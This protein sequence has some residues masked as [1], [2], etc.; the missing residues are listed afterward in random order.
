M[1]A[2]FTSMPETPAPVLLCPSCASSLIYRQSVLREKNPAARW[3][4]FE[5]RTCGPFEYG[6][7]TGELRRTSKRMSWF[8]PACDTRI[9]H[10]GD[11]P[12]AD[13]VYQCHGCGSPL[14]LNPITNLMGA[15]P[16]P[17]TDF[18]ARPRQRRTTDRRTL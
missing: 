17:G 16:R 5:C 3:D 8:C 11:G 12:R 7:H 9:R 18:D 4:Y 15:A 14:A 10:H 6:H 2:T 13:R 1:T